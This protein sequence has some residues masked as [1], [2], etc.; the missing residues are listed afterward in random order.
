MNA[1]AGIDFPTLVWCTDRPSMT[2]L[3][4]SACSAKMIHVHC[5]P[6]VH[7]LF[8]IFK[9]KNP[10]GRYF[11]IV[12]SLFAPED[13]FTSA[14]IQLCLTSTKK[15]L[16]SFLGRKRVSKVYF[17]ILC[18]VTHPW[19]NRRNCQW[20]HYMLS[21]IPPAAEAIGARGAN[22]G[23][24]PAVMYVRAAHTARERTIVIILTR[25][26]ARRVAL[27]NNA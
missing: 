13:A 21:T 7:Q 9:K 4:E 16:A 2:D 3:S 17:I 11:R 12:F 19:E 24:F 23:I 18:L 10:R 22:R 20:R 25:C 8:V 27:R 5:P 1:P 26:V 14:W 6:V 15:T